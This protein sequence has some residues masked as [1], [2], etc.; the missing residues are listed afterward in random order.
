MENA[1]EKKPIE[2][3]NDKIDSLN[4]LMNRVLIKMDVLVDEINDI[5]NIVSTIEDP[6]IVEPTKKIG[7]LFS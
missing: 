4:L 3:V 7:W 5:K 2:L 6:I 1:F